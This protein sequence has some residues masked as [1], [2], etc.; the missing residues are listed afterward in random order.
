[1]PFINLPDFVPRQLLTAALLNQIIAAMEGFATQ[2]ADIAW[3]LT[4][5]GNLDMDS[6]WEIINLRKFWNILNIDEWGSGTGKLQAVLDAAQGMTGGSCVLIPPGF[7]EVQAASTINAGNILIVGCGPSSKLVLNTGGGPLI[8]IANNLSNVGFANFTMDG[9]A[10]TSAVGIQAQRTTN[11]EIRNVRSTGFDGTDIYLTNDGTAGNACID[12]YLAGIRSSSTS[13]AQLDVD[14]CSGLRVIDFLST[15]AGATPITM[16]PDGVNSLLQDIQ[17]TGAR[18][19]AP[20]GKGMELLGGA[21]ADDKWSRISVSDCIVISPT[22]DAYQI[23]DTSKPLKNVTVSNLI[24]EDILQT[25]TDGIAANINRGKITGCKAQEM[26]GDGLDLTDSVDVLVEANHFQDAG[27]Y[28]I[29]ATDTTDCTLVG[30]NVRDA[31]TGGIL[32]VGAAGLTAT[33]NS[34]DIG[35]GSAFIDE[36]TSA[37]TGDLVETTVLTYTIPAYTINKDGDTLKIRCAGNMTSPDSSDT[38]I[39]VRIDNNLIADATPSDAS[40]AWLCDITST[41][42]SV[43]VTGASNLDS[44]QTS[45]AGTPASVKA[46]DSTDTVDF[47]GDIDITVTVQHGSNTA[48]NGWIDTFLIDFISG[49]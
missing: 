23:G 40:A 48:N 27:A 38:V 7:S 25:G 41:I 24:V 15:G 37:H 33:I 32:K 46:Y 13:G 16:E 18:I 14:D 43:G 1:M 3:P 26:V 36:G 4:A 30:N 45:Y 31:T 29:D 49:K 39:R 35:L 9:S 8:T 21:S 47:S 20:T 34:G 28:G 11:L 5:G 10:G 42:N 22:D 12:A 2:T 44:M 19:E 17:I 6:Q